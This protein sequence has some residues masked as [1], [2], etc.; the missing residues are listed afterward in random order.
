[1][2]QGNCQNSK[3]LSSR[4]ANFM[5]QSAQNLYLTH[6]DKSQTPRMLIQASSH[7]KNPT[8]AQP[9]SIPVADASMALRPRICHEHYS[10]MGNWTLTK[11]GKHQ[12]KLNRCLPAEEE[13]ST[14]PTGDLHSDPMTRKRSAPTADAQLWQEDV[15]RLDL[16]EQ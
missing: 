1:M 11:I 9:A 8:S 14:G 7:G 6:R 3:P 10:L 16:D 2:L 5:D 13:T 4:L 15:G 12:K